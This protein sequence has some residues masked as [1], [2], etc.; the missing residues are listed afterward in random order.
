MLK[1]QN[2]IY[3]TQTHILHIYIKFQIHKLTKPSLDSLGLYENPGAKHFM[4]GPL[5]KKHMKTLQKFAYTLF[6][7]A[8]KSVDFG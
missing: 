5:F 6:L 8:S 3:Q 1:I 4:L 2:D 7:V